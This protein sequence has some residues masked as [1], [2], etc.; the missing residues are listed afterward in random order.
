MSS[1]LLYAKSVPISD[2]NEKIKITVPTV[3]EILENEELYSSLITAIIS[4]PYDFMVQLDD[5]GIDFSKITSFDLFLILFNSIQGMD[6]SLV[7][8]D[9]DLSKFKRVV[10]CQNGHV[11]LRDNDNDITIDREIHAQICWALRKINHL[12]KNNK[13][14]ANDEAKRYMLERARIKQRRA[15]KRRRESKLEDLIISMV[16]TEQYKYD[17]AG[18]LGLTIYQFNSSVYQIIKKINYDNTMIGCYSGTVNIKE[19]S[20][21]DLNWLATK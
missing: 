17:Y 19:L 15:S 12:E 21:D 10:N 9:L 5:V 3:G 18:T 13:H 11:V 8:G 20:Q 7:F 1:G 14:P 16:N 2:R 6:T 4:T